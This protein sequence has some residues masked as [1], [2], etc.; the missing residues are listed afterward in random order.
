MK[1]E[2]TCAIVL[3][4]TYDQ[5]LAACAFAGFA[6]VAFFSSA[7]GCGSSVTNPGPTPPT[8]DSGVDGSAG[9]SGVDA[10]GADTSYPDGFALDTYEPDTVFLDT[11]SPDAGALPDVPCDGGACPLPDSYCVDY[12]WLATYTKGSC[13]DGGCV[14][15]RTL[16]DCYA[17][18]GSA[19]ESLPGS[20]AACRTVILK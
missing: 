18:G 20:G 15:V 5:R 3:G 1:R 17:S 7:P 13:A 8:F 10:A 4:V 16:I 2:A 6:A 19:C 11:G 12:R 9:E 14:Y